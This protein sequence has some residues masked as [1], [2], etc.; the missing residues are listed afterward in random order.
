MIQDAPAFV[1]AVKKALPLAAQG[2]LMTFGVVPTQ[3]ETGYGYIKCGARLDGDLYQLDR[4]V[5]KPDL[6]TAGE[7][8]SSGDY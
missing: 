4:F 1:T 6:D 7:Y 8:V 3:P 5:E 2:Q